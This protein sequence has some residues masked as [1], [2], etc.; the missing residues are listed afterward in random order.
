MKHT[1]CKSFALIRPLLLYISL[2]VKWQEHCLCHGH[3]VRGHDG[4]C[5]LVSSLSSVTLSGGRAI[6]EL[7]Y[8]GGVF[9]AAAGLVEVDEV[10]SRG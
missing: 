5:N 4:H 9:I 3:T 8:P 1:A 10:C 2:M 7:A 6:G